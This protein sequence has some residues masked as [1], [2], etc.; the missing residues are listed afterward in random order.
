MEVLNK[1]EPY[2]IHIIGGLIG[3]IVLFLKSYTQEKAKL[4]A[5]KSENSKFD[6]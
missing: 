1:L 6:I 2:F 4:K 5:Q 3:L